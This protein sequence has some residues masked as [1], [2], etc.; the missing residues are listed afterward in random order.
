[1]LASPVL[2][3]GIAV[4]YIDQ[5]FL[6]VSDPKG[7]VAAQAWQRIAASGYRPQK[8]GKPVESEGEIK[9]LIAERARSY[10]GTLLPH[11]RQLGVVE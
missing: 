1:M 11:L 8:D 2:G 7:D 6:G 4:G 3:A 5:C 9:A 10:F